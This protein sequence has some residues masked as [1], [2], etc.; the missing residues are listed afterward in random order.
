MPMQSEPPPIRAIVCKAGPT[1]DQ[2]I[3]PAVIDI[4][5]DLPKHTSDGGAHQTFRMDAHSIR[6]AL[7]ALP[8]GTRDQLLILMLEDTASL[9]R[10]P[11]DD[12]LRCGDLGPWGIRCTRPINHRTEH[13]A[14]GPSGRAVNW[15]IK[16]HY[17]EEQ[18]L[19]RA[20]GE[21]LGHLPDQYHPASGIL[22]SALETETEGG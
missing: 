19:R 14:S 6:D 13:L 18:R 12:Y 20:M 22:R 2:V 10:I 21:A 5:R 7:R 1:G 11:G 8:M 4:S 9:L 3:A 15:P 16:E 17:E